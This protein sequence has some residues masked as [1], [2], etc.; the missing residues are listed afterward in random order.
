MQTTLD[1]E[2]HLLAQARALADRRKTSVDAPVSDPMRFEIGRELP[3][4]DNNPMMERGPAG[5]LAIRRRSGGK[6]VT[7]E[8]INELRDEE[9]ENYFK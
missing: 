9:D 2:D 4:D 8:M 3:V 5:V 6:I 1:I 7:L